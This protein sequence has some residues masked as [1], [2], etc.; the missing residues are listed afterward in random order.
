MVD[1]IPQDYRRA[2]AL[3]GRL[4]LFGAAC[5][6]ALALVGAAR[7]ALEYRIRAER[8]DLVAL[9]Q[10]E[11]LSGAHR[12]K[13]EDLNARTGDAERQLKVLD[14]L[15][16]RAVIAEL[17][18]AVDAAASGKLWFNDFS[19]ARE[20]EVAEVKPEAREAGYFILIPQERRPGAKAGEPAAARAGEPAADKAWR[21]RQHAE[22]RGQA[23]DHS[24]L[25]EF[26]R[27]LGEQP[28]IGPVRLVD[29]RSRSY[30]S[31]QVL[32]FH[33]VAILGTREEAPK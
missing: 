26:I 25:A 31:A 13:L 18:Q 14:A 29:T 19:F 3:R 9:R 8:T 33:L 32:D 6:V 20:G 27:R 22:I 24:A 4:R 12:A 10:S 2:Q 21:T 5:A 7:A 17:F 15:R 1:L 30:T 16:G 23:L 11:V 28:G